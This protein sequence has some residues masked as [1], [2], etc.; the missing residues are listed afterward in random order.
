MTIDVQISLKPKRENKAEK[1]ELWLGFLVKLLKV[2]SF[3]YFLVASEDEE[4]K[5]CIKV[6]YFWK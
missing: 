3:R 5:I 4:L 6:I 1:N 2:Q